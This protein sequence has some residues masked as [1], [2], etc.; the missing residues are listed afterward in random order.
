MITDT[1]AS[2]GIP[3]HPDLITW[4]GWHDGTDE[5]RSVQPA[6]GLM[7]ADG[8][9]LIGDLHLPGLDEALVAHDHAIAG[10][11]KVNPEPAHPWFY[12]PGWFPVL[13]FTDPWTVCIDTLGSAGPAG[14]LFVHDVGVD[15]DPPRVFF[16]SL[17]YLVDAVIET[18]ATGLVS[19]TE[20]L[21]DFTLVPPAAQPLAY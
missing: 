20:P 5:P 2:R 1:L 21:V 13:R 3:P 7:P 15:N 14:T 4:F 9:R 18:Y 17:S 11:L 10:E 6:G 19:P 16:R 8:N 12:W